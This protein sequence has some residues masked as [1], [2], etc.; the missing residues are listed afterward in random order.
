MR[1]HFAVS[2]SVVVAH[3]LVFTSPTYASDLTQAQAISIAKSATTKQ[4]SPDTPCK[5]DARR[6]GTRWYVYVEFTK[7]N[8]PAES[9][10]SYPGGHE[11]IVVDN[12][13]DI[14]ETMRGE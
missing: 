2:W 10:F 6:K 8:S 4:C 5:Y 3:A 7:R 9:P 11:I 12:S 13:G 14:V 1:V